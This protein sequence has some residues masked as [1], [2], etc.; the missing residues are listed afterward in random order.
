MHPKLYLQEPEPRCRLFISRLRPGDRFYFVTD[1]KRI[2]WQV[3]ESEKKKSWSHGGRTFSI[4]IEV[5]NDA[6]EVKFCKAKTEVIFLRK[7]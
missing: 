5:K 2:V 7:A 6:G 1:K 3:Q 4:D